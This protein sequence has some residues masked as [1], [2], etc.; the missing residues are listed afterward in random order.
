M[1]RPLPGFPCH[2]TTKK[3]LVTNHSGPVSYPTGGETLILRPLGLA[4]ADWMGQWANSLSGLYYALVF[5]PVKPGPVTQV[6]VQWF[7]WAGGGEAANG[8]DLSGETLRLM[9]VGV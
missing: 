3:I 8:A 1:D 4:G 9:I 6:T 2:A 5:L 7:T